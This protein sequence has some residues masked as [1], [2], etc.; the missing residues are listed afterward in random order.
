MSIN[1]LSGKAQSVLGPVAKDQLGQ[2]LMHEHLL[3]DLL[4]IFDEPKDPE[5]KALAHAPLTFDNLSWVYRNYC[6]NRD[7]LLLDDPELMVREALAFR[8]AGGGTIVDVGS[9]G[10]RPDPTAL[11]GIS[12][13]TGLHVV[14]G[15]SYYHAFFHPAGMDERSEGT[16]CDEIVQ[17]ITDGIDGTAI[18]AGIIG[19]VGCS[20]P[21]FPNEAKVLRASAHAQRLTGAAITI[22]PGRAA[23]SPFE[24]MDILEA[25]GADPGRVIMGHMERSALPPDRLRALALRGCYLEYDWF[26]EVRPAYPHGRVDVPSDGERIKVIATLL[27]QGFGPQ[28]L[29]SHDVCFKTRL[30]AYGG[31]GYAHIAKY[32]S[33][34]MRV[35]GIGAEAIQDMLVR[36]PARALVFAT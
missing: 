16:I 4:P 22:H 28:V 33:E 34:W 20:S 13:R 6:R 36:N 1:P 24:I 9:R 11:R 25:A 8:R 27:E 26:G 15:C 32:V 19:E 35:L 10:I 23:T 29:V 7:N 21:M 18:K 30:A 3:I 17:D 14:M 5:E 2:I 12:E 31:P